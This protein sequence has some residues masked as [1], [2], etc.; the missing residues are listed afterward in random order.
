[1]VLH[2][3]RKREKR[4]RPRERGC[5]PRVEHLEQRCLLSLTGK[6]TPF[7]PVESL[8]ITHIVGTFT[9]SNTSDP[10]SNFSATIDWGD[11][12]TSNGTVGGGNGTFTVTGTHTYADE[13]SLSV[14]VTLTQTIG[15]NASA[16]ANSTA[17]ISEHDTLT[18][19]PVTFTPV[20]NQS[21]TGTVA[22]FTDTDTA[23]T[24]GDFTA[25][26]NWGDGSS[27]NGTVTNS[28][29]TYTVT[30]THTYTDD[31]AFSATVT[32]TDDGTGTAAGTANSTAAVA[33]GDG[34]AQGTAITATEGTAFTG[35][36]ATFS[37][38]DSLDAASDLTA[39]IIWGDG[40][41]SAGSVSGSASSGF[42]VTGSNTYADDGS[43]T[44]TVRI[45]EGNVKVATATSSVTVAESDLTLTGTNLS[46]NEGQLFAGTLATFTDPGSLDAS[47]DF[48]A[49]IDWGD[50]HSGNLTLS[51]SNGSFTL[52]GSHTY[53]DEGTF[54]A[55]IFLSEGS[56]TLA[57]TTIKATIAERDSLQGSPLTFT[58]TQNVA[59]TGTVANFTDANLANHFVDDF[60]S[61]IDWGDG[62]TAAGVISFNGSGKFAVSGTHTYSQPGTFTVNVTFADDAPS[63]VATTAAS[64]AQ[65]APGNP[66]VPQPLTFTATE[67]VK[68][69]GGT[70]AA[71][72]DSN[73]GD[74][75][76]DFTVTIDW[77]DGTTTGGTLHGDN[78][79]FTVTGTRTYADD[80][81]YTVAVTL[82]YKNGTHSATA[83]STAIVAESDATGTGVAFTATEGTVFTGTV[84][85]FADP[86]SLDAASTFTALITWGDGSHSVGTVS[87]GNGSYTVSGSHLYVEEGSFVTSVT[88]EG[89]GVGALA[90]ASSSTA[91]IA[92]AD[93]LAGTGT[94]LTATKGKGF[95]AAMATF[96]DANP[97]S[98]ALG[99]A[100]TIDWG[101]GSS[102]AGTVI[103][104]AGSFVVL[105]THAYGAVRSFTATVTL[106]DPG[107][108][109]AVAT[110]QSTISVTSGPAGS[111][112]GGGTSGGGQSPAGDGSGA[113]VY[114]DFNH[115]GYTDMAVGILGATVD[116]FSNAGEVEVFYGGPS[117]LGAAPSLTVTEDSANVFN[118]ASAGDEFGFAL[119]TGD[120]NGDGFA[121][122]AIGA[123]FDS[124][125]IRGNAGDV[126]VF[127]GSGTGLGT[128]GAQIWNEQVPGIPHF[129]AVGDH[130][131]YALAAADFNR[132]GCADLAVGIP[133]ESPG[134]VGAISIH[135][136]GSVMLIYGTHAGLAADNSHSWDQTTNGVKGDELPH[137]HFGAALA[138]GDFNGDGYPDLAAGIPDRNVGASQEITG[139]GAVQI[140]YG[141]ATGISAT[142]N[143]YFDLTGAAFH[144]RALDSDGAEAGDHFGFALTSG[145]FNGDGMADLAIGAPGD[146]GTVAN[147]GAVYILYG[148]TSGLTTTGAQRW[149]QAS[150]GGT[151]QTGANFGSAL[152]AG[153][154]NGDGHADLAIGVPN[155]TVNGVANAG[156]VYA[157]YG[158]GGGLG[159]AGNQYWTQES[160]N[161]GSV[162]QAGDLFGSALA[163]G[164]FNG[165]GMA[166]LAI[167][168]PG[169]TIGAAAGAGAVDV[170]YG[171]SV[172]LMAVNDQFW[173]ENSLGGTSNAGDGFGGAL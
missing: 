105:G 30:G 24:A 7:K 173:D 38:A 71:F 96:T 122:L 165:D 31:G 101:D 107:A 28:K 140:L 60:V 164:D 10:A 23:N 125:G 118:K 98:T 97:A 162:S 14:L 8:S 128:S 25:T 109:T 49:I 131:G 89:A 129:S 53:N 36:V 153:D 150:L 99:F 156:A 170:V 72:A 93:S 161:N 143:Q 70:V 102:T 80:G 2:W 154:F 114:G 112:P 160:L 157:V 152:A 115:D 26:I 110:A 133:G 21:F 13:G 84:A 136:A 54:S 87:G 135:D 29:G 124:V 106:S 18:A 57:Q 83:N 123:P 126:F 59:F 145:D 148:S 76:S 171:T 45:S 63:T 15:G 88:L 55:T 1:M 41:T 77:G 27:D 127:Y 172:G 17:N 132:D 46:A 108:G 113:T 121:D 85:T 159:V 9:D 69:A 32:L 91:T 47:S 166:D 65:V 3:W 35:T 48:S 147:A 37:D 146:A 119:A 86:G 56:V 5:R 104:Q 79:A 39:T 103:E 61:T 137:E 78:G 82:A 163:V 167:G 22:T 117:G 100:A 120:F 168:A 111:Q 155:A 138:V 33:D 68:F 20:E 75:Q 92:E 81:T 139:G 44:A 74:K 144:T 11:G 43:F 134:A 19:N 50:R 116:G 64:T 62:S 34:S 151:D 16:T 73:N 67:H 94:T 12:G 90:T 42:T 6:G 40:N 51:G 58:P 66:L 169:K 52:S 141:S 149:T 130:F 158:S 95:T 4:K 142:G